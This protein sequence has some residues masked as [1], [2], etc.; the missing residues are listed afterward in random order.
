MS[1]VVDHVF[2]RLAA[3]YGSAWDRSLGNA[4][5]VDVK[6]VWAEKL[7]SFTGSVESKKR[8]LWALQNLPEKCPNA[9]AFRNLC[10]S[11]PSNEPV[12]LPLPVV[13]PE[14]AKMVINGTKKVLD[15]Q[16]PHDFKAWAKAILRDH[17]GGLRINQTKLQMARD[18]MKEAA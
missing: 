14:I 4:P 7:D 15:G 2:S 11:A 6:T 12:A 1:Q 3:T 13:N 8:V 18:A 10:L 9:I 5:L 17:K 16:Q